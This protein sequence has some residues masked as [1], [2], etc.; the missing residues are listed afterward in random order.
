MGLGNGGRQTKSKVNLKHVAKGMKMKL[1]ADALQT[2]KELIEAIEFV[3]GND[4]MRVWGDPTSAEALAIWER[5][6]K[7][8]LIPSTEFCWGAAGST[9]ASMLGIEP[10]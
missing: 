5:V 2:C 10:N 6:T 4:A 3:G 9:W 7:K 8:G 1:D